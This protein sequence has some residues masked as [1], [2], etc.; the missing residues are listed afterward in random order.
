MDYITLPG[1]D[2]SDE[3]DVLGAMVLGD[4]ATVQR[5]PLARLRVRVQL[6]RVAGV[7][8]DAGTTSPIT[9]SR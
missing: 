5:L 9:A 7:V 3:F 1:N 6:R 2:I 4:N 8:A